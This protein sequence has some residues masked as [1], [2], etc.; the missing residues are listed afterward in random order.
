VSGPGAFPEPVEIRHER[1]ARRVVVTWDDGHL[2][3]FPLDYLRSWCPCASCQG[4]APDAKYLGLEGQELVHVDGVGNYASHHLAGRPQPGIYSPSAAPACPA[5]PAA[6]RN[7][8]VD[9]QAAGGLLRQDRGSRETPRGALEGQHAG[10]LPIVLGP[11]QTID[12]PGS[13]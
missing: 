13:R 6:A 3:V 12:E 5:T 1:Q 2:S 11:D 9:R 8:S 7:G 4:H 10:R